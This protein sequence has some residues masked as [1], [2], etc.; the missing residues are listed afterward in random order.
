M[1]KKIKK[2]LEYAAALLLIFF[3]VLAIGGV[4]LVR[5]YEDEVKEY[6]LKEINAS[7]DT[8]ITVENIEVSFFQRFPYV[9]IVLEEVN[10]WSGRDFSQQDFP[11]IN[12]DTLFHAKTVYFQ[13]NPLYLLKNE[14]KIGRIQAVSG[15]VHLYSDL[16]GRGNFHFL[17]DGSAETESSPLFIDLKRVELK[18]FDFRYLS[19]TN[20]TE[21]EGSVGQLALNGKFSKKEYELLTQARLDIRRFSIGEATYLKDQELRFRIGMA[22]SD[23]L[24]LI[25]TGSVGLD[26]ITMNASG[27]FI[28]HRGGGVELDL[29]PSAENIELQKIIPLLPSTVTSR[30]KE[31]AVRGS[32]SLNSRVKGL[33]APGSLPEIDASILLHRGMVDF[34]GAPYPIENISLNGRISNDKSLP[35]EPLTFSAETFEFTSAKD[36]V[37]GN[38]TFI[39]GRRNQLYGKVAGA[40]RAENLPAWYPDLPVTSSSGLLNFDLGF[41]AVFSGSGGA[42]GEFYLQ[43]EVNTDQAT[44]AFPWYE[45]PFTGLNGTL[46]ID[47]SKLDI[48]LKGKTGL[49]DFHFEGIAGNLPGYLATETE[50]LSIQGKLS[51]QVFDIDQLIDS[52]R[53]RGDDED[54]VIHMPRQILAHIYFDADT[55]HYRNITATTASGTASY[56]GSVLNIDH[57]TMNTMNGMISGRCALGQLPDYSF[58]F[59]L[60]AG[61]D[62]INIQKMFLS[63]ENFGQDFITDRNLMGKISGSGDL[64]F[65]L[66]SAFTMLYPQLQCESSV[67]V[68]DGELVDF[69][70]LSALSSFIN[71]EELKDIRFARLENNIVITG[72][73]VI[74]PE[75]MVSNSAINLSASGEHDF[76]NLYEYHVRLKLSDLLYN[77]AKKDRE[78][79]FES[80]ADERDQRTL[81]LKIYDHGPGMKVEYDRE[82]AAEKIRSDLKNEKQE[83]KVLFNEELGLFKKDSAL[84]KSSTLPAGNQ[85]LF[86]FE[87]QNEERSDT[88]RNEGVKTGLRKDRKK[89]S[90][91]E[92]KPDFKIVIDENDR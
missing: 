89:K 58:L 34:P 60:S 90:G 49:S 35:G 17:K 37:S 19:L 71:I 75:M 67:L 27:S 20:R 38:M 68:T 51:G 25:R 72:G 30:F 23:S 85:P 43:G 6:A 61:F 82:Q 70:P 80:A 48:D 53:S 2:Y 8:R 69:E 26:D 54:S 24:F 64:T 77:K 14:Y 44:F 39:Y 13:F 78:L 4:V 46:R 22:V 45:T 9:S 3:L 33:M 11:A 81:F 52:Y 16:S 12:T 79:G 83:L 65:P 57:F 84:Q 92:N 91:E 10:A 47:G 73:K 29:S 55:L 62:R 88:L 15:K 56:S 5:F 7:L 66:T 86:R 28:I 63:F 41:S 76:D 18:D 21:L 50:N 74:I 36:R 1:L 31:V 32:V 42:P 59:N 87:F 40:L